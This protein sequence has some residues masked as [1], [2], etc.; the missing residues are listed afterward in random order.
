MLHYVGL[1][2]SLKETF[3]SIL[4]ESGQVVFEQVVPSDV[5]GLHSCL[6]QA[7]YDYQLIGM[8]S[9]QLS[10]PLCKGL[11]ALGYPIE[12]VDA[13][14][15]AAALSARINK[16]DQ[17]DARG[18]AQMLRANL[19]KRVEIKS[20]ASCERKVLLRSRDQIKESVSRIKNT[21]RGLLKIYGIKLASNMSTKKFI[22]SVEDSV[23]LTPSIAA[24]SIRSLLS[25]LVELHSSLQKL[26][27]KLSSLSEEDESCRLL[28]SIP[29]V[30]V[31]TA[32]TFMATIDD[33]C[34]FEK[35]ETVG[36][37]LG[38]TPRQY[39]SGEIDR[40]GSISKMGPKA[41]RAVLY[42]AAHHLLVLSKK[43]SK[44]KSWGLKLQ[45]KKG[46]KKA[47]VAVARKLAVVM[48][49]ML[50]DKTEFRYQ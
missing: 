11:S 4:D 35:S 47:T 38:L 45:K 12:C 1:D 27:K 13:R 23:D 41:C 44:L 5:D 28:M 48:H 26:D 30:G 32:T 31:V 46:L 29:S 49:R 34:R 19:Y 8:E 25:S 21:A 2:V 17:N 42:E 10:I 14:H 43:K 33:P 50:V 39:A 6:K 18:I 40:H 37:Y 22:V 36:A 9:G 16:N 7:G 20:E 24:F 3:V 15:M